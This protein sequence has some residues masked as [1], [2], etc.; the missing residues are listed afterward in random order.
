MAGCAELQVNFNISEYFAELVF[1]QA[2]C[3]VFTPEMLAKMKCDK[4]LE[5]FVG[6][7]G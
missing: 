4:V 6:A 3:N 1:D 5:C 7:W 2:P